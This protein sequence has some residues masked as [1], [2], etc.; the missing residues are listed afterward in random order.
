M[1]ARSV[2]AVAVLAWVVAAACGSNNTNRNEDEI[3]PETV[4]EDGLVDGI[5]LDAPDWLPND[6]PVP[7]GWSIRH[8][9]NQTDAFSTT[10]VLTGFLPDGDAATIVDSLRAGFEEAGYEM[11]LAADGFVPIGNVAF[12]ALGDDPGLVVMVDATTAELPA[13]ADDDICPWVDGILVGM[14][15]DD[16]DPAAARASYA[17][18]FLTVGTAN[19]TI[20]GQDFS[21][22]GECFVHDGEFRFN[23]TDGAGIALQVSEFEGEVLGFGS[24]DVEDEA[25]F[26]LDVTP[27]SG[28]DPVFGITDDGFFVEGMFVDAFGDLGIV[29]GRIEANCSP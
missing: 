13:K 19:A 24:V 3:C 7:E 5:D 4:A 28:V 16:V 21:G 20:A 9:N 27:V 17:G 2:L 23:A 22:T 12:V 10:R 6:L 1:R 26:P 18:S 11:L 25:V 14:R 29:A 8:A 15:F